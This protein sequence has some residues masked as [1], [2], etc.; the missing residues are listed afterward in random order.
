M[1]LF[2]DEYTMTRLL[3]YDDLTTNLA[4]PAFPEYDDVGRNLSYDEFTM[5]HASSLRWRCDKAV[6]T[7]LPDLVFLNYDDPTSTV[8]ESL[9]PNS[10]N[11]IP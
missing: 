5:S 4:G 11:I 3:E 1:F 8:S 10:I 2:Y 7:K 9:N 6:I